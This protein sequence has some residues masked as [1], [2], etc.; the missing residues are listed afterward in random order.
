MALVSLVRVSKQ[1]KDVQAV[2]DVSL[3]VRDGEFVTLLGPSGCGK[4]TMLNCI[5]GL[6][7]VSAGEIR[8]DDV[9]VN[10]LSPADRNIAMVFQDYALYPH[11]SVYENLTFG[12]RH[13]KLDRDEAR[14]RATRAAEMLG[15]GALLNRRPSALSGGQRQR[16][17]LGRALVRDAVLFLMDEPLSNLDA[18]LRVRTRTEIKA[19]QQQIGTTTIY[20]THDQEEAMVLSDRIA[21]MRDGVIQQFDR[22][23]VIYHDP[24]N[25]VVATF[26][27]NPAMNRLDGTLS[28]D[29]GQLRFVHPDVT[30]PLSS[31]VLKTDQAASAAG[32][33]VHLG[34]RPEAIRLHRQPSDDQVFTAEVFLVEL[35]GPVT[36]VDLKRGNVLLRASVDPALNPKVGETF[37]VSI[38]PDKTYVFDAGDGRRL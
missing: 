3:Q 22:P 33:N 19:L 17:A 35:I 21:V 25:L 12:L 8:F 5:A 23:E 1:F 38:S 32:R 15:I 27:G 37:H 20:V 14:Q 6:E 36:Y 9:V 28:A 30:L 31:D 7:T 2:K 24:A 26:I 11:M 34:I 10:Q 18:A 4:T 13:R 16:V 29:N